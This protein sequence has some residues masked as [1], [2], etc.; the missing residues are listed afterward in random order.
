MIAEDGSDMPQLPTYIV[1]AP[2]LNV[3]SGGALA[4]NEL[5]ETLASLGE[6]SLV[7]PLGKPRD[8]EDR[9]LVEEAGFRCE[10]ARAG[11]LDDSAIV[12]YPEVVQ[13][14]PLQAA[15]VVRWLL[16]KPGRLT[17]SYNFGPDEMFFAYSG[18]ADDPPLTGGAPRLFT[19][20][21]NPV[22]RERNGGQRTGSC[23][24]VRKGKD[25]AF[26]HP[27]DAV[28][29]DERSHDEIAAAFNAAET[30]YCYD[31]ATLYSQYAALCG[32]TS[33]VVPG[34]YPDRAAW[35][36]ARPVARYGVAFGLDDIEHAVATRHL[37]LD[38]LE[39]HAEAGRASVG[40]FAALTRAQ[41]GFPPPD[42]RGP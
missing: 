29:L 11:D 38:H 3:N 25:K 34:L 39:R 32:C 19:L 1:Y 14:N 21:L 24:M 28:Q 36:Q 37:V 33:I 13:G 26:V 6:R 42:Q 27:P 30:F 16:N 5:A 9:D 7:W 31:E 35:V 2:T 10:V 41:F 8:A 20:T 22:Y 23:F 12:I 4:M 15:Q 18:Y 17:G 40:A